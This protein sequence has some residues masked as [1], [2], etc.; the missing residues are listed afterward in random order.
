MKN[1]NQTCETCYAVACSKYNSKNPSCQN[2]SPRVG[3][4]P[5]NEYLIRKEQ[6][7]KEDEEKV[8][9]ILKK[10]CD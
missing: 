4:I 3:T 8:E 1:S 9:N 10:L 6:I 5:Y 2:Y 7:A